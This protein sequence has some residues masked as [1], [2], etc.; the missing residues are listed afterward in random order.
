MAPSPDNRKV[1]PPERPREAGPATERN[2]IELLGAL[3]DLTLNVFTDRSEALGK[4]ELAPAKT[5]RS[6]ASLLRNFRP[7]PERS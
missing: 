3:L 5:L 1:E 6:L 4:E 2:S 7:P